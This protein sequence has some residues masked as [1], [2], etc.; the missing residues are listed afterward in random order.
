MERP[1]GYYTDTVGT[2]EDIMEAAVDLLVLAED[3]PH[4]VVT[5]C[6]QGIAVATAKCGYGVTQ[7]R[8]DLVR[9]AIQEDLAVLI[10]LVEDYRP[11]CEEENQENA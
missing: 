6:L 2:Q 8:V 1:P 5:E 10:Q 3:Y 4:P 9:K 7:H 11:F